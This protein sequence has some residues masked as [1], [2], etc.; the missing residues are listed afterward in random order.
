M[1]LTPSSRAALTLPVGSDMAKMGLGEISQAA[2]FRM[3]DKPILT[4]EARAAASKANKANEQQ[5]PPIVADWH[6][7][8]GA[9]WVLST[10]AQNNP[11]CQKQLFDQGAFQTVM[12]LLMR[13]TEDRVIA[14]A[15][16]VVSGMSYQPQ[17]HEPVRSE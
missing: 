15:L 13:E 10:M 5:Q 17:Q 9:C 12:W 4:P 8:E 11:F 7:R 1:C 14:K 3:D 6:V 16:G 2:R